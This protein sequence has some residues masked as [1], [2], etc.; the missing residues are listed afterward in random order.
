MRQPFL[1]LCLILLGLGFHQN[2]NAD[3]DWFGNEKPKK[4]EK[5]ATPAPEPTP[6]TTPAPPITQPAPSQPTAVPPPSNPQPTA[7]PQ[8]QNPSVAASRF[9]VGE[10]VLVQWKNK[11]WKATVLQAE[12]DRFYISY[13]G[14]ASS[15]DEWVGP[16]RIRPRATSGGQFAPGD[17][18]RVKWKGSWWKAHVVQVQGNR[19]YISYDGYSSSWNEWVGPSR[20][21]S[22]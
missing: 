12:G 14:Y 11:W 22:R 8:P 21:R 19:Y 2:A 18:V 10:K 1:I 16:E 4:Q 13:D 7:N 17:A 15:W 9:S 3:D 20:I 6:T 5:Q